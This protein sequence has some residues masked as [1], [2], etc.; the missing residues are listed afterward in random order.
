MSLQTTLAANAAL[1]LSKANVVGVGIGIKVKGGRK[2]DKPCITVLVAEKLPLQALAP[3]D[4]VPKFIAGYPTDV[5][6][7]G[8]FQ[9]LALLQGTKAAA[10]GTSIGHYRITAGTFGAV[11]YDQ[12][13]STPLILSNNHVLANSSNG[14]DHRAYIGDPILHPGPSDGG[15]LPDSLIA[16]LTRF[17]VLNFLAADHQTATWQNSLATQLTNL[18]DAAVAEPLPDKLLEPEILGI[19]PVTGTREA[20]LD[21]PVQKSGRTT[22]VTQGIILL[23]NAAVR[24]SYGSAGMAIFT[25]QIIGDIPS[26]PGDSGSLVVDN[27][28]RAVGLL[29]AGGGGL[30][31]CNPISHVERL[32]QIRMLPA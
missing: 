20:E 13:N 8:P 23:L 11:V 25:D 18:V 30:T 15:R 4:V 27:E 21:L 17:Q 31:V 2:T 12:R 16:K 7:G 22:G 3:A 32:L 5:I 9:A 29:F 6:T 28:R 24:V 1:L 26:A 10:P 14:R 19:G